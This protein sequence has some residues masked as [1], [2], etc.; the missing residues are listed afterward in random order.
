[1]IEYTATAGALGMLWAGVAWR[2]RGSTWMWIAALVGALVGILVKPTTGIFYLLPLI[3]YRPEWETSTRL[4]AFVRA[5]LDI[6]L[7]ALVNGLVAWE[8]IPQSPNLRL[9]LVSA[10]ALAMIAAY[11]WPR[12]QLAFMAALAVG[13]A[14]LPYATAPVYV[15]RSFFGTHRVVES[16]D[17][18]YRLLLHGTT[19]HGAQLNTEAGVRP[20]PIGYYH[21]SGPLGRGV[22]LA[23][24]AK[25]GPQS[26]LRMGVV[27]LGT[28]ALACY[29]RPGDSL[30]FFEI[31]PAVAR[32]A[33]TPAYF[34]FLSACAPQA[35]ILENMDTC[36]REYG[37][38][39]HIR[40]RMALV[41][42]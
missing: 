20:P 38:L 33:T 4:R 12:L 7:I 40:S 16:A 22:Q 1:M 18:A 11:R 2:D 34:K 15:T 24:T 32:I 21:Q 39:D 30:R 19:V 28:G 36:A 29:A 41:P 3:A 31:D 10:L 6:G 27:G 25:G 35:E 13:V 26:P 9:Y 8:T 17:G 14:V 23:R 37:I 5:R 42:S